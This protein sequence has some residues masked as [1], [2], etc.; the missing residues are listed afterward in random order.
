MKSELKT[1]LQVGMDLGYVAGL[2]KA[3]KIAVKTGSSYDICN[4]I[5]KLLSKLDD[6]WKNDNKTNKN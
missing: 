6:K 1:M 2:Q 3:L 4:K 5:T